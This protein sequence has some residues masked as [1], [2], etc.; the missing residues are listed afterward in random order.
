MKMNQRL[1]RTGAACFVSIL[2]GA[3]GLAGL[4]SPA[5]DAAPTAVTVPYPPDSIATL[6]P[7]DWAGQILI[8]QGTIFEGLYGY[9]AKNQIV[10]KIAR[11]AVPSQGERVWT[12]YLRHNAKW[13]NG[14]PVTA[15]DFKYAWMRLLS[16]TSNGATW[17]GVEGV[18]LNGDAY[19]AGAASASQVGIKVINPYELKLTLSVATNPE[20]LL[21]LSASM[22]LYPPSV[23]QHPSNWFMPKYFVGDGPYVVHSFVPNGPFTLTRNPHYVGGPGYNVGNVQEIHL[24]PAPSVSVEDYLSNKLDAA[25]I[26]SPSDYRYALAHFKNQVHKAPAAI[27]NALNWDHS[28]VASP[29]NDQRVREAI[30]MAI[31]RRPIINPVLHNMVGWTT[32]FSIPGLPT[33]P[34]EHNP[35]AYNVAAARKLLAEAG[36]PH[37][38]GIP[39]LYLYTPTVAS[40]PNAVAMAEAI[41][42]ELKTSL[43][44][45]FKIEPTN[46]TEFGVIDF[47]GLAPGIKPGYAVA[48]A[49]V[50]WNQPLNWPFQADQ[51]V[52]KSGT[53]GSQAFRQYAAQHWWF[54]TT[55]DPR[56]IKLWGNPT[57]S[58]LGVSYAQWKPL[59]AAAKKDIAFLNAWTAKQPAAYQA[60]VNGPG[61]IPLAQSLTHFESMFHQA[62]TAA[63]KHAAWKLLW[64][65]VGSGRDPYE[66]QGLNAQ[67]YVDQHESSLE[68]HMRIWM[69]ELANVGSSTKAAQLSAD[70]GNAMIKS[71]YMI[72][73]NYVENVYLEKPHLTGV[74]ANPWAWG[75]FY[76]LQYMRVK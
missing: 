51:W 42:Q 60:T 31:N 12:I 39:Q 69:G 44:L 8:D 72:P 56:D 9:N 67:V 38:R 19:Q 43:N 26:L 54:P 36:Y 55:Y 32:V 24:I 6:D 75:Y 58:R 52:A 22:P 73:L 45:H 2:C 21:A 11:K 20:G 5:A 27:I 33:Y 46:A 64:Q 66:F 14:Q 53:V 10:P 74:V 76:Q 28:T 13:S 30:A 16:P 70:M 47:G 3:A 61:T 23:K 49:Q 41:A 25:L 17:A 15:Q 29:L 40:N 63:A 71:G 59:I 65:W 7:I 62:K 1:Q 48:I 68:Y 18:I 34:L 57:N 50:N 35:Y 37:G 4:P